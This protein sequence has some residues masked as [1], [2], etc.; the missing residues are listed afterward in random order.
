M[1]ILPLIVAAAAAG[2]VLLLFLGL[3]GTAPVDPVQARL[4]QLGSMQ[5]RNLEELE[6]QQPFLERTLRPLASRLSG[7]VARVTSASFAER[8]QHSNVRGGLRKFRISAAESSAASPLLPSRATARSISGSPT[9]WAS[10]PCPRSS[11]RRS[12]SC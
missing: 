4:T 10:R 2:A 9:G 3:A 5:A 6:L 11:S 12:S 8:T 7:S 1:P